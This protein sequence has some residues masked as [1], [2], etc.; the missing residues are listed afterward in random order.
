MI[1]LGVQ[2]QALL[3]CVILTPSAGC[4][5]TPK[6]VPIG[7][8]SI[9]GIAKGDR[10]QVRWAAGG[11]IEMIRITSINEIGFTG[12]GNRGRRVAANYD[13]T[14]EIGHRSRAN[15]PLTRTGRVAD[16]VL[17]AVAATMFATAGAAV[18]AAAPTECLQL[19]GEVATDP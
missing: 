7:E 1:R 6:Y 17:T 4:G 14:Y 3:I 13:E 18:C 9:Y 15:Q 19:L 16:K 10:V 8:D 11:E 5:T 2:I 12:I